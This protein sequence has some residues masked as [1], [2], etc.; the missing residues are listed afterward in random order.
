MNEQYEAFYL[1]LKPYSSGDSPKTHSFRGHSV[2]TE[3]LLLGGEVQAGM[4]PTMTVYTA[5]LF[6]EVCIA[7]HSQCLANEQH[8]SI[9]KAHQLFYYKLCWIL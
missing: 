7:C 4:Y 2:V 9:F 6:L 5:K 1:K 3:I 8:N